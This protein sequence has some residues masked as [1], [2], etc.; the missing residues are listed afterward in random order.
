M[1]R[2]DCFAVR[3]TSVHL[4]A[5]PAQADREPIYMLSDF[6]FSF[7]AVQFQCKDYCFQTSCY[8]QVWNKMVNY[9]ILVLVEM[10]QKQND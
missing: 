5:N 4:P 2:S 10:S 7:Q 3:H 8:I 1:Y 6:S 9:K